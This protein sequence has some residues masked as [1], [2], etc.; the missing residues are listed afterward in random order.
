MKIFFPIDGTPG[1][2]VVVGQGFLDGFNDD[3][4][5][6][7]L[8]GL[9]GATFSFDGELQLTNI[10][11]RNGDLKK[12]A[13]PYMGKLIAI[14]R[15]WAQDQKP[16]KASGFRA[17]LRMPWAVEPVSSPSLPV[18][19]PVAEPEVVASEPA[20]VEHVDPWTNDPDYDYVRVPGRAVL[21]RRLK[22]S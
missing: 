20:P 7:N 11:L 8:K 17:A 3:H 14:V 9:A 10:H 6:S 15:D 1:C 16:P 12:L 4:P 19:A 13:G 5:E 2:R 18:A 22:A 21:R